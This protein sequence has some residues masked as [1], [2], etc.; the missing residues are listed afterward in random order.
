MNG[1]LTSVAA[2]EHDSDATRTAVQTRNEDLTSPGITST[3]I[4][5]PEDTKTIARIATSKKNA[6][7]NSDS[8]Q[9]FGGSP[10]YW[11]SIA[12]I[13]LQI[14]DALDYAHEQGVV[15]RDIKPANLLLD[16]Q[17][18]V[19]ITDFGLAKAIDQDLSLI[20]I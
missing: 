6:S 1:R 13:G 18:T 2:T 8:A 10:V 17:G 7:A 15:H 12:K 4:L 14:A 11:Q 19:W 9:A 20:H 5:D 16:A 3:A